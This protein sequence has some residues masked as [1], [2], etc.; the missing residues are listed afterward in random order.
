MRI[1]ARCRYGIAAL[2]RL[3]ELSAK[4]G[5]VSILTLSEELDISKIYLEQVFAKLRGNGIVTS[6]K[7]ASGGYKLSKNAA[8]ISLRDIVY[9]L[10]E[11]FSEK[12]YETVK[13]KA[14]EIDS[15]IAES[16][17]ALDEGI[18]KMLSET[19]LETLCKKALDKK[20]G[21]AY[22]FYI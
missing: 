19:S 10:E 18:Q 9:A 22:M 21:Q 14:P 15:V 20:S 6:I 11:A 7:G 4:S 5:A 2:I 12:S 8:D 16:F 13:E 17:N 3:S 1:S